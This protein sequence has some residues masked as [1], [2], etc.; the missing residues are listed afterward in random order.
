MRTIFAENSTYED[1]R[2]AL[3]KLSKKQIVLFACD[4]A[5]KVLP[6]FKEAHPDDKHLREVIEA[7]I[8]YKNYTEA[9]LK[10]YADDADN[11]ANDVW[12][13]IAVDNASWVA[14]VTWAARAVTESARSAAD[15]VGATGNDT[16]LG[17]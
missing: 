1:N 7:A 3:K 16:F 12:A 10:Q 9:E 14:K 11:V 6:I 13:T 17:C 15:V 8:N 4:C 5:L 2:E